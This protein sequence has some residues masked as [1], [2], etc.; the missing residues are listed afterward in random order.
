M[1]LKPSVWTDRLYGRY[2]HE[3]ESLRLRFRTETM[4]FLMKTIYKLPTTELS[5][6]IPTDIPL[7]PP[8]LDD[9]CLPPYHPL[10]P[11]APQDKDH[12]DFD[13]LMKIVK[14]MQP[15]VVVELGTAYGNTVANICRQCPQ[16]KVYT[17]NAPAED[18]TGEVVT[19]E[20]GRDE[21]GRVYKAYG[22]SDRVVQ[23]FKN[24][25]DLNLSEYFSQAIIDLAIIDACHD[26]N[27]VINDFFKVKPYMRSQGIVL[28]HDTHHCMAGHL[29]G[30]YMACMLLRSKG[31]DVRHI[32]NTWWGIWVNRT[33]TDKDDK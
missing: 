3:M 1:S 32:K 6:I 16:T 2:K 26:T 33:R 10:P 25:L 23:V 21:I 29:F 30:S 24:T 13:S 28:F 27:Y 19:F 4:P 15:S 8:I 17:V 14:A 20:L 31:Y 5:S 7:E 9:A 11:W 18:Q 22:F 12:N